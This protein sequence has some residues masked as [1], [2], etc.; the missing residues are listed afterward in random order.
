MP[1]LPE[2]DEP[3]SSPCALHELDDTFL[4][5]APPAEVIAALNEL[6][7]AERAG[8][9]VA[10]DSAVTAPDDAARALL[11]D[12]K[13]DEAQWCT[14]LSAEIKQLGGAP[15]HTVGAF[16]GKAMAIADLRERLVF[17]NK[18]QAWVARRIAK[19]LPR[20]RPG[21]LH[22]NLSKMLEGHETNIARTDDFIGG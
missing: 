22:T 17:L 5:Y 12:V 10:H 8:V 2:P 19:L 18:G 3:S 9:K 7:E 20:L 16:H 21:A 11:E 1:S 13:R 15:S 14:M 4:G 6:L